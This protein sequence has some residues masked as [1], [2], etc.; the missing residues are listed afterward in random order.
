MARFKPIVVP[1]PADGSTL[2]EADFLRQKVSMLEAELEK[3]MGLLPSKRKLESYRRA[4]AL[5]VEVKHQLASDQFEDKQRLRVL[6][7]RWAQVT[8][9]KVKYNKAAVA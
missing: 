7:D 8:G 6:V 5:A 4:E 9:F 3:T 2:T 1:A